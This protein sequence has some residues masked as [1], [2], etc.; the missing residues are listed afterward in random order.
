MGQSTWRITGSYKKGGGRGREKERQWQ[1]WEWFILK[2]ELDLPRTPV[3]SGSCGWGETK[4]KPQIL[5]WSSQNVEFGSHC[6]SSSAR[7][8]WDCFLES[9][10]NKFVSWNTKF[11]IIRWKGKRQE[12]EAG[13][14]LWIWGQPGL[15]DVEPVK[16][17]L[18]NAREGGGRQIKK[19]CL[20]GVNLV[21][22]F[23]LCPPARYPQ[24]L[25][26][27]FLRTS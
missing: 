22:F 6:H 10:D 21:A 15:H 12:A 20:A 14:S 19:P 5:L 8:I 2:E 9:D 1:K 16:P 4:P 17:C 13:G 11:V 27:G 26:W 23:L 7:L 24:L 25:V 3:G 18:R